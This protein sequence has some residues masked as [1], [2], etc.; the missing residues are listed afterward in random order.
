MRLL[1]EQLTE[2]YHI[3]KEKETNPR[4]KPKKESEKCSY[5]I[6]LLKN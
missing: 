4:A 1:H 5:L 6:I 3:K 2:R